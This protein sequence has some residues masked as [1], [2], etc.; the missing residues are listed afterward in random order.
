MTDMT[1]EQMREMDKERLVKFW[2]WCGWEWHPA[3]RLWKSPPPESCLVYGI[4]PTLTLDNIF[5]YAVPKLFELGYDYKLC[6]DDGYHSVRIVKNCSDEVVVNSIS[7][8]D[9]NKAWQEA[10][11]QLMNS[12]NGEKY[13]D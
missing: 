8:L 12:D 13:A 6:S 9:P 5:K 7:H 4:L 1:P 3:I 2:K 11:L 10:V